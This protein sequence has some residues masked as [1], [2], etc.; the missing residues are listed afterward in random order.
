MANL[1]SICVIVPTLNAGAEWDTTVRSIL[2]QRIAPEQVLI[3]D[4]QS[5]DGTAE[6]ARECGFQVVEMERS[7]FNHGGTRQ[8]AL[9]FVPAAEIVVYMTQDGILAS[10]DALEKLIVAFDDPAVVGAF[11]RQLPRISA[12]PIEVHARLFNYPERSSV[13]TLATRDVLGVKTIFFSNSFGAYRRSALDEVGGF[14]SNVILGEDT[15]TAARLLLA[16]WSLSYVADAQVRHSH[17]YSGMQEFRRYFDTGVL[18]AQE[19]WLLEKF[20]RTG[21]EGSRFVLS[22][23]AYLWKHRPILILSAIWRN[24]LKLAGYRLGKLERRL[25]RGLKRRLSM[26]HG[27]WSIE[28]PGE[29]S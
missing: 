24:A 19:P 23:L 4:S 27:F 18:H 25:S 6:R 7:R 17:P 12:G 14:P 9:Q 5:T 10:D 8:W 26:H 11:G 29:C 2:R 22:E 1:S 16:G 13:R 21:G 3:V 15:V 20:G 28:K